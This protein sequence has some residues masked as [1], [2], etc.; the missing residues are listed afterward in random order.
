MHVSDCASDRPEK[1]PAG[2]IVQ[3]TCSACEYRSE[4]LEFDTVTEAKRGLPCPRCAIP[5]NDEMV[6]GFLDGYKLDNPEPSANRSHSYRH[7]F[8]NGRDDRNGKPRAD[9]VALRKMAHE[10]M[11]KDAEK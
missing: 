9:A 3:M 2:C 5:A 10:A 11:E 4:W 1:R 8:A 6:A 7:G